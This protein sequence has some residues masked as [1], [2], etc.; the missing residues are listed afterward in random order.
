LDSETVVDFDDRDFRPDEPA[1]ATYVLPAA[2]VSEAKFFAQVGKD[3]QARLVANRALEIFRNK[4]LKLSSRP[5]E[6]EEAFLARCDEAGEAEGAPAGETED[7]SLAR[8]DE[9]GRAEAGAEAAKLKTRLE[10]KKDRLE[11]ALALSKL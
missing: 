2:P 11:N 4:Q 10:T 8:C 7:A 9:A 6:T 3:V 1:G 5:G